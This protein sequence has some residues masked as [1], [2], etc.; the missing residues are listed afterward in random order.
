MFAASRPPLY[1][2]ILELPETPEQM[3]DFEKRQL[4]VNVALNLQDYSDVMRAGFYPSGVSKSVR[5]IERHIS[6]YGAYWKS[7]DFKPV[8]PKERP[9]RRRNLKAHPTGPFW[10]E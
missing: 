9:A 5:L 4:G 6:S 2:L 10:T 8:D 3:L 7:Y 1:N